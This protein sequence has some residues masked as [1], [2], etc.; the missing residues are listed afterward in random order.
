MQVL[1][2]EANYANK[3]VAANVTTDRIVILGVGAEQELAA[4]FRDWKTEKKG[5]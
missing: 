4:E 5:T 3:Q 1:H 2:W